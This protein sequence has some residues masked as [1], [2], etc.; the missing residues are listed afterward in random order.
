MKTFRIFVMIITVITLG[1]VSCSQQQTEATRTKIAAESTKTAAGENTGKIAEMMDAG[2]Y[3]YVL[4]DNGAEKVWAAAPKFE[5]KVGDKVYMPTKVMP[6]TNYRSSTLNR[7]FDVVYFEGEIRK[8]ADGMPMANS[9]KDLLMSSHGGALP[10][11]HAAIDSAMPAG[12]A[13]TS[14]NR[15]VAEK[16]SDMDLTQIKKADGGQTVAE[17]YAD[18]SQLAGKLIILRGKVVKFTP[19]V[20]GKNWLHVQD[21]SGQSGS[22]DLTVTTN[23]TAKIG[24]TVLVKGSLARDKDFGFGYKYDLLVEDAQITIE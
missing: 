12:H 24:D 22:N 7:T 10:A 9:E 4:V 15:T 21:G 16:P 19:G 1:S 23:V 6:M 14:Q 5:A 17:V 8:V 11:G 18:K 13:A 3:T 2:E 20:M